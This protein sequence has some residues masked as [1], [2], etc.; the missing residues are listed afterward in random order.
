MKIIAVPVAARGF[1][2]IRQECGREL[3]R[4]YVFFLKNDLH[5]RPFALLEDVFVHESSRGQGLGREI[6][7]EA[8]ARAK[9]AGCYKII[10]TSRHARPAVHDLYRSLGFVDHGK[11]FRLGLMLAA[12][13]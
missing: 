13:P 1:K 6:V 3:A 8:V 12:T 4:A 7:A 11:E 2:L 10:A 5:P 9:E